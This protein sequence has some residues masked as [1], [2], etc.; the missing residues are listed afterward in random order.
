MSFGESCLGDS[1]PYLDKIKGKIRYFE[2]ISP[3]IIPNFDGFYSI[4]STT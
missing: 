3:P 2:A 4:I 1:T